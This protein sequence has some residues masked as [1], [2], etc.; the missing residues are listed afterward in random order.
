MELT[1]ALVVGVLIG[2]F[3]SIFVHREKDVGTLM[4]NTSDPDGPYLF[5]ALNGPVENT[6]IGRTHVTMKVDIS[7][8]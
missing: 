4:V 5:V 3:V 8:N 2:Y 7:Q 6:I 1:I